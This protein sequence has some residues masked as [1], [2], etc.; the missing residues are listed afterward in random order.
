M[1][2][3][4]NQ[5]SECLSSLEGINAENPGIGPVFCYVCSNYTNEVIS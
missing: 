4:K 5:C 2:G 1:G 3:E